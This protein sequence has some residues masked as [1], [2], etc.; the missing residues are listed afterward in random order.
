MKKINL[1]AVEGGDKSADAA[2]VPNV[3]SIVLR[4]QPRPGAGIATGELMDRMAIQAKLD[5]AT[6][7]G[8]GVLLLEDAEFTKLKAWL[9]VFEWAVATPELS[10]AVGAVL[11]A[12]TVAVAEI[13]N[14]AKAA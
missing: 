13:V 11:H 5:D 9:D 7:R 14:G 1:Q 8:A 12:E 4:G 3:L 6:K 2:T 10:Q